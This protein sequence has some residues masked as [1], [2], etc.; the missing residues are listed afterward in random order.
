MRSPQ[1]SKPQPRHS[2]SSPT[3]DPVWGIRFCVI[4]TVTSGVMATL[5]SQLQSQSSLMA[6]APQPTVP[7]T[8]ATVES[9]PQ[10]QQ[11]PEPEAVMG[12]VVRQPVSIEVPTPSTT[13][14][15]PE[16]NH[17]QILQET[18]SPHLSQSEKSVEK[19]AIQVPQFPVDIVELNERLEP[20][21]TRLKRP[22]PFVSLP[23][24]SE[25]IQ[26]IITAEPLITKNQD[27]AHSGIQLNLREVVI[28]ALENNRTIK[29]QYLERII[30]Q[31]DLIVEEDKFVPDFT[32]NL[33]IEWEN[34]EQGETT[35]VTNGLVLSARVVML[36]PTGGE[37]NL[38][39]EGRGEQRDGPGFNGSDADQIRQNLELSLRQPLL[40][41]GGTDVNRA[42]I[43]I[44]RITDK[45]NVLNLKSTL[46]NQITEAILAYRQLIQAQER[47][48]I[49]QNS[50]EIAQQQIENTQALIDAGRRAR[51]DIVP[52]KTRVAN[53][54]VS[55][56]EAE[57]NLQ[58]R[59]LDLLEILDVSKPVKIIASDV[60]AVEPQAIELEKI[61]KKAL[62]N[63]P[64]YLRAKLSIEQANFAL[65][66]AENQRKWNLDLEANVNHNPAPNVVDDRTEFRAGINLTKQLGDRSIE[67]DFKQRKVELLQAENDLN[68][69][70]Q[71]IEIE[72]KNRIRD[73][74]E[75]FRK[76]ELSRRAT[77][78]AE[79]QLFN[80]E[81]RVKLGAGDT[82]IVDLVQFQESLGQAKNDELNAKIDYLN[83]LTNLEQT[84]GT[85]LE[86]WDIMIEIE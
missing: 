46:I 14:V 45:I 37:I 32:P 16:I 31:Q 83:A 71:Q 26:P 65:K 36:L 49:E 57:N 38:G 20:L 52:V 2:P 13:T 64:D 39:W 18:P 11:I 12:R 3:S 33:S 25:N 61:K 60:Q 79:E 43:E 50:L 42:S 81:Q 5:M 75:N 48:K 80:Q 17:S 77:Q 1:N 27:Q 82:S 59:Q 47:L 19:S 9:L 53:Q 29:N 44:A 15:I 76:V 58:Q 67:R 66:V 62:E 86:A 24:E 51:V 22:K 10:P 63:R 21:P 8:P 69:E 4:V 73:V 78:L 54:E 70:L 34:L 56:L 74:Q 6:K 85:T 30:Q 40:R 7:L 55:L 23:T 68:E 41:N 84:I 35:S 72:V 28:L